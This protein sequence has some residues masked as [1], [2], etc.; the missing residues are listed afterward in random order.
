MTKLCMWLLFYLW[1]LAK[2][3]KLAW[4]TI[5]VNQRDIV[6]HCQKR[7]ESIL[8]WRHFCA[9]LPHPHVCQAGGMNYISQKDFV[10]CYGIFSG[11][12]DT[13]RSRKIQIWMLL[14]GLSVELHWPSV[15]SLRV[16]LVV[17][18]GNVVG[19]LG[20]RKSIP[21]HITSPASDVSCLHF[22]DVVS[23]CS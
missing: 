15:I 5:S 22:L 2:V 17:V 12:L 7:A 8:G 9:V 13:S 14:K 11:Q 6:S 10:L 19:M 23:L 4:Y 20:H 16:H 21:L 1:I 18:N 3:L